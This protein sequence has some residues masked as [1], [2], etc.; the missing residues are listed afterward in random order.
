MDT[1]NDED[2]KESLYQIFSRD[3]DYTENDEYFR[4]N[5]LKLGY[6]DEADR[7]VSEYIRNHSRIDSLPKIERAV[8]KLADTVFDK[9]YYRDYQYSV[10]RVNRNIYS[11]SIAYSI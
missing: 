11:V 2:I 5:T 7:L 9:N 4:K 1:N 6:K 8:K 10:E 3:L